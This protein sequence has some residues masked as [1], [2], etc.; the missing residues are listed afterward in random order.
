M[1][2]YHQMIYIP[3]YHKAHNKE[4][5]S[6]LY[7]YL[8]TVKF[9][10]KNAVAGQTSRISILPWIFWHFLWEKELAHNSVNKN[11]APFL[12]ALHKL[13]Y[14]SLPHK[15]R[16]SW[17]KMRKWYWV[18]FISRGET[19]ATTASAV[20]EKLFTFAVT[21]ISFEHDK[22]KQKSPAYILRKIQQWK[23]RAMH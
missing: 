5:M 3:S 9:C 11:R 2:L 22:N 13:G 4:Q 21:D 1:H 12:I 8:Y 18:V 17:T 19:H 6:G 23:N 10:N 14:V 15:H 16:Y 20:K 7:G